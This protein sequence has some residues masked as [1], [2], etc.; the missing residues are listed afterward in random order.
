MIAES[1]G[2]R[3]GASLG[4]AGCR[5][6]GRPARRARRP[7]RP[8]PRRPRARRV[9]R[10]RRLARARGRARLRGAGQPGCAPEPSSS[11][12]A[13]SPARP[14]SPPT[15]PACLRDLGLDP[16][17]VV[18]RRG[19]EHRRRARGGRPLGPLRRARGRRRP[20]R[21]ARRAARPHPRRP[22]RAGAARPRPRL[23]RPL[24]GGDAVRPRPLPPPAARRHPGAVPGLGRGGGPRPGGTTR[25]TRTP[26]SPGCGPAVPSPTWSATSGRASPRRWPARPP[27]ARRRRRPR[28]AGRRAPWPT[29]G[30]QPWAVEALAGI[31]A[32]GAHP[33]L[34]AAAR[35]GRGAGRPGG[36]PAHRRAATG[37]SPPGTGRARCTP[38]ATCWWPDPVVGSPSPP[39]IGLTR[40]HHPPA[41]HP[42]RSRSGRRRHG[43]RPRTVLI[44]EEEIQAKL[45]ELAGEIDR[46][47]DGQGPPARRRAQGGGHGD[48]RPDARPAAPCRWTGWRCRPTARAPSPPASCAS[49]R[50][51]TP[52]SP[53]ATC[54][55]SRTSSTRA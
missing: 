27:A 42:T 8:R 23:G 6:G 34:A 3:D 35:R 37:C 2:W 19:R 36:H 33:V 9:Q 38:P 53:A 32:C 51:S 39:P 46:D 55:S 12:T 21:R 14:G 44:T 43:S 10:R 17:D 29:L 30:P 20:A 48:G 40:P 5:D 47:Y 28:R 31:P 50:T 4:I 7:G 11:T 15:P 24:P 1:G 45:A 41:P 22:G 13:C 49:S 52:T 25:R 18:T 16:V 26:P 54:S